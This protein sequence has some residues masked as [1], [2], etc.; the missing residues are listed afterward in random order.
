MNNQ[1]KYET[2]NKSLYGFPTQWECEIIKYLGNNDDHDY[3][4]VQGNEVFMKQDEY[5][6]HLGNLNTLTSKPWES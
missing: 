5:S 6:R 4:L 1:L 2:H 3:W